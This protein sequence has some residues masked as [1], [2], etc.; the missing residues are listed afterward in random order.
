VRLGNISGFNL[1]FRLF[2]LLLLLLS[3]VG[4]GNLVGVGLLVFRIDTIVRVGFTFFESL[5][6]LVVAYVRGVW[7]VSCLDW[8]S[9]DDREE[10]ED[11]EGYLPA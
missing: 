11:R 5:A 1:I 3:V 7:L 9:G 4:I 2:S 8:T 6:G 10:R